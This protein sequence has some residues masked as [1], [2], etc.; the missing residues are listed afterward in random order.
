MARIYCAG[1][2]FNPP[3]RREMEEIATA[4]ERAGHETYLPQRDGLE[5]ARLEPIIAG[6]AEPH[7][8]SNLLH[9]A[10]FNFDIFKLL[11][12]S[13]G[14]VANL[15][16]RVPDEGTVVEAAL[17]WHSGKALVIYKHDSRAAFAGRDNPMLTGLTD[18]QIAGTPTDLLQHMGEQLVAA[19]NRRVESALS[20]GNRVN[21]VRARTQDPKAVAHALLDIIGA[22]QR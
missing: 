6:V 16:G 15:N 21:A 20:I 10:I 18:G 4:L 12:W 19:R 17:A 13:E 11:S 8:A 1:P 2:L 9:R 3:E 22:T 7:L 14:V 5:L